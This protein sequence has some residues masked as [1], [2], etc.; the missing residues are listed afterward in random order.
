VYRR[1]TDGLERE[2]LRQA[3]GIVAQRRMEILLDSRQEPNAQELHG[4]DELDPRFSWELSM[5][6]EQMDVA[7]GRQNTAAASVI[8]ATVRVESYLLGGDTLVEL[9]RYIGSLEPL[10]GREMAVPFPDQPSSPILEELR[11]LLGH[12][13]SLDEIIEELIR[14]GEIDED[15]ADELKGKSLDAQLDLPRPK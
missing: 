1:T 12:E 3:A 6:R 8:K 11:E 13:P 7:G 10:A 4:Q 15:M 5:A 14:R 2:G 9:E